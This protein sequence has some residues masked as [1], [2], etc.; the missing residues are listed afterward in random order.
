[1]LLSFYVMI[2][3]AKILTLSNLDDIIDA[4]EAGKIVCL[5]TD[6]VYAISC[7]A[8]HD[9]SVD[10]IY[11][12]KKRET[13]K[14]LPVFLS[15]I[16]MAARYVYLPLRAISF[17][18]RFW[19]GALT[20]VLPKAPNSYIPPILVKDG[21]LAVRMPNAPLIQAI[22][23]K[24][25][26]PIIATSANISSAPSIIL[27]KEI[28]SVFGDEV[29]V[30]VEEERVINKDATPSTIIEFINDVSYKVIR[31]GRIS[32]EELEIFNSTL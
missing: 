3:S 11:A 7:D 1:M 19:P 6:T 2:K 10:R 30:I 9:S 32:K 25:N 21:K 4:F 18:Q 20:I 27:G 8:T 16:E 24:L 5:P 22:C 12:I 23:E 17:M 29:D 26:R 31:E 14:P 28:E 13:T 15:S